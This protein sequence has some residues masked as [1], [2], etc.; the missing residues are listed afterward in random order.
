MHGPL[1]VLLIDDDRDDYLLTRELLVE[2]IG[3]DLVLD[4]APSY[5]AGLAQLVRREHD[6]CLLDFRLGAKTGLELLV[7]ARPLNTEAPIILLT[8]QGQRDIDVTAL[9]AGAADFLMKDQLQADTLERAVRYALERQRN[10]AA[11]QRL[12]EELEHRVEQRT[13]ELHEANR[14][15]T[16]ADRR[17]DEFLA[18]LAHELRNPMA[19][20]MN[21][22]QLMKHA[23]NDVEVCRQARETM[24]RQLNQLV[25]LTEDLLEVSRI[26][27]GKIE[28]RREPIDLGP[29]IHQA[30][31][32]AR[33]LYS[34]RRQTL[35]VHLP[36]EPVY[37]KADP[38]RLAQVVSNLLNN[39]A[40]FTGVE[41]R[42]DLSVERRPTDVVIRVRDDGIGIAAD[43]LH[44]I[45]EMF[46]QVGTVLERTETGLGI[47]LTLVKS[48]VEM[49][50]GTIEA[51]SDGLGRGSEFIVVLPSSG[52]TAPPPTANVEAKSCPPR[53]GRYILV[54][55][56]NRDAASSLT[57]LLNLAGYQATAV[58]TGNE[59][60]TAA[61][62]SPPEMILLD[63][64][65]PDL[66]GYEVAKRLRVSFA[67]RPLM[68][69]ALTGWGQET[70]RRRAKEAGFDH[71]LLKPVDF[72]LLKQL[73][74][75]LPTVGA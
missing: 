20:I 23:S 64:G 21:S 46:T 11:L 10:L 55:D 24:E 25:R 70:D 39:A 29:V 73:I 53:A 36:A 47:G 74:G 16:E 61:N 13:C 22:L 58:F 32:A 38:A 65:L 26:S 50:G 41:G 57:M 52:A 35:N 12:N 14:A 37:L 56:D 30:V 1:R 48:L 2:A 15:L 42:V 6:V 7:E 69:V 33:P 27:R 44:R 3:K 59:A 63:I 8:G 60:L 75:Q 68:L 62:R 54:V 34:A 45:F 51:R 19:P 5:E 49:H 18:V 9:Q 43:Q 28:L 72:G 4:W 40:K 66:N 31:E 71:H 17:K 67:G